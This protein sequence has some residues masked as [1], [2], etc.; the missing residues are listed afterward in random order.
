MTDTRILLVDDDPF[1]RDALGQLLESEGH[2]VL[3]AA[4]LQEAQAAVRA[5]GDLDA[6]VSDL[7]LPDGDALQLLN[8]LKDLRPNVPAVVFSGVGTV[9]HAVE[10]MKAGALDFLSKPVDAD[11]LLAIVR[12][13]V[14]HHGL[15]EEVRRLRAAMGPEEGQPQI[16]GS[17]RALRDAM[18]VARKAAGS[19]AR[20]LLYGESGT[21]KELLAYQI[22]RWSRRA[23]RPF[24]RVNCAAIAESLFESEMFGHRKGAFTGATEDRAGQFA[25]ADGGT[26]ALDEVGTLAPD[27][28]AKLLRV[29]ESGEYTP[30]GDSRVR[31]A[32]VRVIAITNEELRERV[33]AGSFR[34]DL[35][36]RLN[37]VPV[38]LPPLR[39]RKEDLPEL[40]DYL[41]LQ[42][43]RRDGGPRR[44][45]D[46]RALEILKN[47]DWPGNIREL[48]NVLEQAAIFAETPVIPA[49]TLAAILE[50]GMLG[51]A[52]PPEPGEP[53]AEPA[54]AGSTGP[55][56][57]GVELGDDLTLRTKTEEFQRVVIREALSRSHGRRSECARL[58][59]ID[60]RNLAYYLRKHGLMEEG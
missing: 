60:A 16:V 7:R 44:R 23:K 37:V 35:F 56:I 14:E 34:E 43:A 17:S 59:G 48:R 15:V 54:A 22:H 26:L 4:N 21:G 8:I 12:R 5:P 13:A 46:A 45:C 18:H 25:A 51:A 10:A 2:E 38:A 20:V 27:S 1:V 39:E 3:R 41:L 40:A 6:I 55:A 32:D 36:F 52:P 50:G 53:G 24:V 42:I 31:R 49:S 19:D 33:K 9:K 28:Q 57:A 29:L 58:L 30:V 11:A 47:H